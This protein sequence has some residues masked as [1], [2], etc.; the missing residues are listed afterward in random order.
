MS[1]P[2]RYL[3][4]PFDLWSSHTAVIR[5]SGMELGCILVRLV[6]VRLTA[7]RC[8]GCVLWVAGNGLSPLFNC[9]AGSFTTRT[10]RT[11]EVTHTQTLI[12][13]SNTRSMNEC[14]LSYTQK[15]TKHGCILMATGQHRTWVSF[16]MQYHT[17][18]C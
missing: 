4:S 14:Y 13:T 1:S 17:Q 12:K 18:C 8:G 11:L 3:I 15:I 9:H 16:V 2:K 6:A 10:C 5:S 7:E